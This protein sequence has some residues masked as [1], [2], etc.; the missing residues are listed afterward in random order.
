M[1]GVRLDE[2]LE[3]RLSA[4][5]EKLDRSKSYLAKE[6]LIRYIEAEEAKDYEKQEALARWE[7]YQETGEVV[8]N[9]AM[10]EWLDSWG[11]DEEKSCPVK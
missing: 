9:E 5:A 10:M 6:A 1:L 7:A 4:L 2:Q 3:K 8:S 11:A